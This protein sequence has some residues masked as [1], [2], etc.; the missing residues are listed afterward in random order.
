MNYDLYLHI[1]CDCDFV[2]PDV[3]PTFVI[4]VFVFV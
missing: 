2:K 1:T 3:E 4:S